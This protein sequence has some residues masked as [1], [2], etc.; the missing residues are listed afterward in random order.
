MVSVLYILIE[1]TSNPVREI[2]LCLFL[3]ILQMRKQRCREFTDLLKA[4]QLVSVRYGIQNQAR[5]PPNRCLWLFCLQSPQRETLKD[6]Q[7]LGKKNIPESTKTFPSHSKVFTMILWR[8]SGGLYL[9]PIT[10][11]LH[12]TFR[13][14]LKLILEEAYKSYHYNLSSYFLQVNGIT[15]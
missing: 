10:Q 13:F 11:C 8:K 15:F 2:P 9:Y 6:Q 1:S 12:K 7:S 5:W 14:G 3:L 4:T